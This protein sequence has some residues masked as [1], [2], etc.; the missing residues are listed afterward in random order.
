MDATGSGCPIAVVG[1]G[2]V[3]PDAPDVRTFWQNLQTGRYSISDVDPARWDPSFYYDADPKAPDKTYSKIGGWV[4]EWTWDPFG[5]HLPIPPRVG[6]QL[7]DAQKWAI[8]CT[9]EALDDYGYPSRALEPEHTAVILG[10]A[11]GG[12]HHYLS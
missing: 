3:L 2:C 4:R 7:D 5:W 11:L 9:R 12:E 1:L 6:D 10:S 8:A